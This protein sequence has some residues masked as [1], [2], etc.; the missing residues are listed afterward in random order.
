MLADVISHL[1]CPHCGLA[2]TMSGPSLRCDAGHAFDIA[3]QG[4]VSLLPGDARTGSADTAEM[5]RARQEL[6]E[7]GH[8]AAV[9]EAV[10]G[11][12]A[13]LVGP[14]EQGCVVDVGAG[15]GHYLRAVLR[16]LPRAIGLALD[17]SK[18][19]ARRAARADKRVG[20][21]VCDAW[22]RL[23]IRDAATALAL[24]VFAPRNADELWRVLRPGGGL[25][26]VTPT[27]SHLAELRK[28]LGLLDVDQDKPRRLAAQLDRH[29]VREQQDEVRA[30][31]QL[32]PADAQRVV[33]MGPNA[34]HRDAA[35]VAAA[36]EQL[37]ESLAVTLSVNVGVYRRRNVV[38]GLAGSAP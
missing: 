33:M 8:F 30:D 3:R 6:L 14:D 16:R 5:V 18:H 2:L 9:V 15:T 25:L 17:L 29:F 11:R 10:A 26:V 27:Q 1:A 32:T 7:D 23:P 12:A 21:V 22:A 24:S 38:V 31:L 35:G 4:Y 36:L 37:G 20:A 19:A 13:S 34:W 28:P